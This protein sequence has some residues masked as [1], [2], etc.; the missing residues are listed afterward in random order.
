MA[1]SATHKK[2]TVVHGGGGSRVEH[3]VIVFDSDATVEVPSKLGVIYSASFVK[4][5]ASGDAN[6]LS[7]N[8][9]AAGDGVVVPQGGFVTVDGTGNTSNT[10]LYRFEGR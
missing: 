9:T 3:G 10:Y 7:I 8:E 5:G 4:V 6:T 2:E 1:A